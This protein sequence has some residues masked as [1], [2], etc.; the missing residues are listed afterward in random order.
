MKK[1]KK[2]P[3][4][5]TRSP[6]QPGLTCDSS[7]LLQVLGVLRWDAEEAALKK[8]YIWLIGRRNEPRDRAGRRSSY[9]G[10]TRWTVD[11]C[12]LRGMD[13]LA[14]QCRCFLNYFPGRLC[15]AFRMMASTSL[16]DSETL[17]LEATGLKSFI[18]AQGGRGGDSVVLPEVGQCGW[19]NSSRGLPKKQPEVL[20]PLQTFRLLLRVRTSYIFPSPLKM[21]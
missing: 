17:K 2:C 20:P 1:N 10:G 21:P 7:S 11:G 8:K 14:N 19:N 18:P 16:Q 15:S 12:P 9:S 13:S 5:I 4:G 6:N 3:R